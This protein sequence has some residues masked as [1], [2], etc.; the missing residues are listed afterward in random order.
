MPPLGWIILPLA[1]IALITGAI[2]IA[3]GLNTASAQ[4]TSMGVA[5]IGGLIGSTL[6]TLLVVPAAYEFIDDL[7]LWFRKSLSVFGGSRAQGAKPEGDG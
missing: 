7:R 3:I 1:S 5:I 6:L 4:R 2:P